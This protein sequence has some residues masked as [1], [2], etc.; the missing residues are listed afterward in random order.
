VKPRLLAAYTEK[1]LVLYLRPQ[2]VVSMEPC[3]PSED[4][5]RF[6][7]VAFMGGQYRVLRAPR[8]AKPLHTLWEESL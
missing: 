7:V 8:A 5:H 4:G 3:E 1:G 6:Y 2:A